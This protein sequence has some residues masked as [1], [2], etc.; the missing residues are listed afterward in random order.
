MIGSILSRLIA[1]AALLV[2]GWFVYEFRRFVDFNRYQ[3]FTRAP[4]FRLDHANGHVERWYPSEKRWRDQ[5]AER[6][7]STFQT[8][9]AAPTPQSW[10]RVEPSKEKNP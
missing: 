7:S 6:E 5:F 8:P 9:P 10:L 3:H 1:V 2:A 4:F